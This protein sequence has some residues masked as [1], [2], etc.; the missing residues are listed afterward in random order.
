MGKLNN[1]IKVGNWGLYFSFNLLQVI[2]K[3]QKPWSP[4][5]NLEAIC[6]TMEHVVILKFKY[7][8]IFVAFL[9]VGLRGQH[10]APEPTYYM[11]Y[12]N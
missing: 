10:K 6:T 4:P 1:W 2:K 3:Q 11:G 8:V 12:S 9:A 7:D 5:R